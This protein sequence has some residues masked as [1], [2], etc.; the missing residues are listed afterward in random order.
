M[1]IIA[2]GYGV[3]SGTMTQREILARGFRDSGRTYAGRIIYE[4]EDVRIAHDPEDNWFTKYRVNK[5]GRGN[6]KP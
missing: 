3:T 4:N 5:N 1:K 6:Q 2:H